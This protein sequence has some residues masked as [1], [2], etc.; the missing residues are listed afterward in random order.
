MGMVRFDKAD[1]MAY[2]SIRFFTVRPLRWVELLVLVTCLFEDLLVYHRRC[3]KFFGNGRCKE[4]MPDAC[5]CFA[6]IN[7]EVVLR[8]NPNAGTRRELSSFL[9]PN[10]DVGHKH[11]FLWVGFCGTISN[12]KDGGRFGTRLASNAF[13]RID[14]LKKEGKEMREIDISFRLCQSVIQSLTSSSIVYSDGFIIQVCTD[15][16]SAML[17]RLSGSFNSV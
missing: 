17:S 14:C 3:K 10:D 11:H 9:V 4:I 5:R 8:E 13:E 1:T 2:C 15:A 6:L 16:Q 7:V 12:L